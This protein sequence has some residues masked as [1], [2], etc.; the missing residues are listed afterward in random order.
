[1]ASHR[2]PLTLILG[3]TLALSLVTP[4]RSSTADTNTLLLNWLNTQ[5]NVQ[6]W[7]A[8]VLQTRN[9][10]SLVQ[11]LTATGHVWF[12]APNLFR[13]EL[14]NPPQT[15]AV[16]QPHR[17]LVIYPRLKRVETYP[18]TNGT[19]GA[20][21]DALALLEAGFP[22]SLQELQSRFRLLSI[23]STLAT[24]QI[25]LQPLAP[26]ARRLMPR[27]KIFLDPEGSALL[28][29]ELEFADGSSMRNDFTNTTLNPSLE[30]RLFDPPLDPDWQIVHPNAAP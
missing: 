6:S 9:L 20:W 18:L 1:M 21:R 10:K 17:M 25:A 8:D 26:S 16:R 28:G 12:A 23:D 24:H 13:W 19:G 4:S 14:G 11:P 22:R 5:T 29:T 2:S 30:P 3:L 7:S 15:I 27:I